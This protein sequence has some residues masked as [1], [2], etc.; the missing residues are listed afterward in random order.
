[1]DAVSAH[2]VMFD[3][4]WVSDPTAWL[5]LLTLVV[6]EIVLGIDNL[7]FIAIL[8]A[9]LPPSKRDKARYAGLGGALVI[10]LILLTF[11]SYI[12]SMTKPLF[13]IATFGVSGRDIVM[14]IGGVFLLYKAT[15]EL[16]SKL[17]GFDEELSVS[18]A[19]GQAF[20]MV[21][22]QIMVLDAVFSLDAIITAVGMIDHV[23]I[24]MFAVVIAMGIMTLASKMITDFVS[25]HPTLVILCLGFLLLIGFSLIVEALHFHVP[26]GYLYAA[27]G[28]S[29]V[30]EIFNQ[31]ARRNTLNL[32]PQ[33]NSM[34]SRE[35][36]ANLVLRLLGSNQNQVQTL[37]EAIV[38][39][40]GSQVF[41]FEEKEMV[42][43]VLQL[44]SLPIKAVMT[45][46][47]DVEMID[48]S[49]DKTEI[50]HEV[51]N[52]SRS[53]LVAYK[54]GQKDRP[55][56]YVRRL[57]VMSQALENKD[58]I[59]LTKLVREPLYLPESISIL[60]ALE[61]F[62][63]LKKNIALVY[64]EFGNF[65]GIICLHDILEEIAGE[66]PEQAEVPELVRVKNGV[67]RIEGDAILKDV[68]RLT[69]FNVPVSERYHTIAG[70][71]LDYLQRVPQ[72]GEHIVLPRWEI[73]IL[74]ADATSIDAI[75]LTSLV[76]REKAVKESKEYPKPSA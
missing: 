21:V 4:A 46:R 3:M 20:G 32:G 25:S 68:S 10:R 43:R 50:L 12:V 49:K 44:S 6:I 13:H 8:S 31:V 51:C 34:Q 28:F 75:L 29:I 30:I 33:A 73:E 52:L 60:K 76:K 63:K 45:A 62:R 54:D 42:S 48:L 72:E 9:K 65:E 22:L 15:H 16:H 23:F 18:K 27:I 47:T 71:I 36:A 41:N 14:F 61:E 35:V 64:D 2:Q 40:T 55:V 1:M 56:G 53:R 66:L 37:K 26:K 69:G 58:E 74:K 39:R 11:I 7:V 17:E 19:A 38:S 67:W 57:D 59:D 24:M 5:G 70:F